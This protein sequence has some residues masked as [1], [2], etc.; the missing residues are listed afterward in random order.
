MTRLS[1]A[2]YL[3]HLRTESA[4][5]RDALVDADPGAQVPSCPDWRAIDLLAHMTEVQSWWAERLET[6]PAPPGSEDNPPADRGEWTDML[7]AYDDAHARL[8][9]AL[10]GLDPGEAVW[11]WSSKEED[12]SVRFLGRRQALE[13][14]IHRVD[15]EQTA[16][17]S[18]DAQLS[19]I[20]AELAT[21]GV[22]E[23]LDVM[24]GGCPPWGEFSPLP[25]YVRVDCT[26]TDTSIWV[27]LGRFHGV[28]PRDEVTYDDDDIHVVADP[29]TEPDGTISGTSADL[30]LRFWRRGD[31]AATHVAGDLEI[32]DHFRRAV[33]HPIT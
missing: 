16:G 2:R 22:D 30:L 27:Q 3:E 20:D 10:D 21:D 7:A 25:H 6:R 29:G 14:L 28:N 18:V 26:D 11:T 13:A 32:I 17:G 4:R 1:H 19:P 31:G 33:H 15:A 8:M 5:F 23:V 9:A 24:Y 12:H